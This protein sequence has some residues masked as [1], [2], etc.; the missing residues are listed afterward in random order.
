MVASSKGG[1]GGGQGLRKKGVCSVSLCSLS[2]SVR[3]EVREMTSLGAAVA[4]GLAQGVWQD[5]T[6][7]PSLQSTAFHPSISPDSESLAAPQLVIAVQ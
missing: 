3:P 7:L 4:A 6:H 1:G 5:S 2:S